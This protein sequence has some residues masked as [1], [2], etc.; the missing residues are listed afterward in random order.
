[1]HLPAFRPD[2]ASARPGEGR[3]AQFRCIRPPS[4]CGIQSLFARHGSLPDSDAG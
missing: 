3:R 2:L 1:L 4:H